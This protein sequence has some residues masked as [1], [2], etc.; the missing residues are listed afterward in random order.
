MTVDDALKG[1]LLETIDV[2][3]NELDNKLRNSFNLFDKKNNGKISLKNLPNVV[4]HAGL[5]L[6]EE[7][8]KKAVVDLDVNG[9][10]RIFY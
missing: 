5:T 9:D 3:Y 1:K 7:D 8:F 4:K 10:G 2:R 6:C